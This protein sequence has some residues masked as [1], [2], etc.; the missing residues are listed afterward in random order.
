MQERILWDVFVKT[1]A[2]EAYLLYRI[3]KAEGR[4]ADVSQDGGTG[5]AGGSLSGRG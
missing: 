3:A 4:K 2:P 5:P 1:G